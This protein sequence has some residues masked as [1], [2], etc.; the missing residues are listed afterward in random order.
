MLFQVQA[1]FSVSV[2]VDPE[3]DNAIDK[4]IEALNDGNA[5]FQT[6][7]DLIEEMNHY[8]DDMFVSYDNE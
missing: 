7:S 4:I 3:D 6:H 5:F 2:V 8:A 1:N